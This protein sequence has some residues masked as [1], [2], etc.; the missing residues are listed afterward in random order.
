[1]PRF[2]GMGPFGCGPMTGRSMGPCGGGMGYGRG[3]GRGYGW[4]EA[5]G[6]V[7]K[8]EEKELLER[9]AKVL[10]NQIEQIQ[11]RIAEIKG[12]K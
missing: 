1:M 6:D 4:T 2:N 8:E 5:P 12:Q 11:K 10:E 7:T 9:E 3:Q